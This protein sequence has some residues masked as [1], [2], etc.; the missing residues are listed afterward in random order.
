MALESKNLT[1]VDLLNRLLFN[2]TNFSYMIRRPNK[3]PT[4]VRNWSITRLANIAYLVYVIYDI[5]V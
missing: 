1:F 4:N 3:N 2:S 5:T